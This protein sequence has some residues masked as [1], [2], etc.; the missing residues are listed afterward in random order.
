MYNWALTLVVLLR[1]CAILTDATGQTSLNT[2]MVRLFLLTRP[3]ICRTTQNDLKAGLLSIY[4][5]LALTAC[6]ERI[7][8]RRSDFAIHGIDVSH[9]QSRIDWTQLNQQ[10][11]HFAF[12]K[13]TEGEDLIDS[14]FE[15]NWCKAQETG[16]KR[17]AYHFFRPNI[18]VLNQVL[19]F[20]KTVHLEPGDLPPVLDVEVLDGV[21]SDNMEPL[22][23]GWLTMVEAH[24]GVKPILYSN[25]TFYNTHLGSAFNDH[26]LWIARYSKDKPLL[27]K[28]QRWQF[29]Q[30]GDRARL[31]GI[32]GYVDLN[33]FDG[34]WEDFE[35]LLIRPESENANPTVAPDSEL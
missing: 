10:N 34:S 12:I 29:W 3:D 19:N 1:T 31:G 16:I 21:A 17:G 5:I 22:I 15:H 27:E 35:R 18:P 23:R 13:A 24:Y 2:G 20:I 33:V 9:Y 6:R 11:I 8:E 30:Y 7:T 26:L 4:V 32:G 28:D 25:Q 14:L